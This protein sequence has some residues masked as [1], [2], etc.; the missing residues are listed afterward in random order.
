MK[1]VQRKVFATAV[2]ILFCFA[3]NNKNT[4]Q[5]DNKEIV[6]SNT[7]VSENLKKDFKESNFKSIED[8]SYKLYHLSE[9][10][11]KEIFKENTNEYANF[12][13][14]YFDIELAN[15]SDIVDYP[16]P[17]Y[18][19]LND[20][21]QYLSFMIKDRLQ[22]EANGNNYNCVNSTYER[23]FGKSKSA[24]FFLVFNKINEENIT[25]QYNDDYFNNGAIRLK[26][27]I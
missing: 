22:L 26:L 23:T 18:L 8:V 16:S 25:F 21:I 1:L 19:N 20:K 7:S 11:L 24:R 9:N 27:A 13:C 10:S 3:C 5:F 2:F 6:K 14:F 17:N 12:T 15:E 4:Q